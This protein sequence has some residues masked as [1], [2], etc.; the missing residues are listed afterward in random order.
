MSD[1]DKK[2][3]PPPPPIEPEIRVI[4]EFVPSKSKK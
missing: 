2:K 4:K 1:K 3:N